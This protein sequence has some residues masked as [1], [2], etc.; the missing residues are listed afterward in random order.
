VRR[1][2]AELGEHVLLQRGLDVAAVDRA[3]V[4]LGGRHPVVEQLAQ[5]VGRGRGDALLLDDGALLGRVDAAGHQAPA[6]LGQLARLGQAHRGPATQR[7]VIAQPR[8]GPAIAQHPGRGARHRHRQQQAVA[9]A[10][11]LRPPGLRGDR[12]RVGESRLE[13]QRR[14]S[15]SS[16]GR[17]FYHRPPRRAF[18]TGLAFTTRATTQMGRLGPA[19]A[20]T[21]RTLP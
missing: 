3:L 9:V 7:V 14:E 8:A 1:L 20:G 4:A 10:D 6:F 19:K 21:R 5:R 12:E 18:T 11:A 17:G 13:G 16:H 2:G 15:V